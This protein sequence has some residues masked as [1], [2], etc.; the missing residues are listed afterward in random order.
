MIYVILGMHKSGTT[1]VARALHESG[2]F[3]GQD[4]PH[5][6]DYGAQK[7][8][9]E[10]VQDINDRILKADRR[11]NSL[12]FTSRLLPS[13]AP[14]EDIV[15]KARACI[16]GLDKRH[17]RWGF[18]DPLTT[19]TYPLWREFLPSHRVIILYR[20]PVEVWRRYARYI[21]SRRFRKPLKVWCD[22]NG[23]MLSYME[24]IPPENRIVLGFR[25]LLSGE[26]EWRRLESFAGVGLVD[27]RDPKQS[28]NSFSGNGNGRLLYRW[29]R[30]FGGVSIRRIHRTLKEYHARSRLE[31]V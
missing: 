2:I 9:A 12:E 1:L 10:W 25:E 23:R 31:H 19:L 6:A 8:E 20:D 21:D 16:A 24:S 27:V 28:V 30:I 18:K 26:R 7:Y 15:G 11:L 4:F 3:M 29:L 22:Y 14:G 17:T 5:A 13:G